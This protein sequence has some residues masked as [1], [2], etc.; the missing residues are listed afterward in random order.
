MVVFKIEGNT[1]NPSFEKC[2]EFPFDAGEKRETTCQTDLVLPTITLE[3]EFFVK[4]EG[5]WIRFEQK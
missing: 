3:R 4:F 5:Q 2:L 1:Y